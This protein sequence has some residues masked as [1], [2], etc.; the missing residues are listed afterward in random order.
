MN[1]KVKGSLGMAL[2]LVA[3]VGIRVS[4][5]HHQRTEVTAPAEDNTITPA[6]D[7][8]FLK[9]MRPETPKDE[10]DLVGKPLWVAA[11]GQMDY[12]PYTAHHADYAHKTG[13]LLGAEKITVLD[14]FEQVAPAS[15][16]QRIH[17]GDRQ[18]LLAFTKEGDEKQY[19]VPVGYHEGGRYTFYT[20]GIFFYDDPH[21]L[22]DYWGQKKWA[23]IDRHEAISGMS[24]H[25]AQLALGQVSKLEGENL[26][27]R[28]VVYDNLGKPFRVVFQRD[29]AVSI[30]PD[31]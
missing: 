18:V 30:H 5:I 25:Q 2:V 20:D 26:G 1:S 19:A 17:R 31:N 27:D 23:A 29:K 13:T 21:Q 15:V 14:A 12:Y 6:D 22:Y 10:K 28:T 3:A 8:V 24:E 16:L 9:K 4:M 7:L 11:G